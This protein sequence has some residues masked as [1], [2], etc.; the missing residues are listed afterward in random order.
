M[1]SPAVILLTQNASG[2][3]LAVFAFRARLYGQHLK[4]KHRSGLRLPTQAKQFACFSG[5]IGKKAK[6]K[7]RMGVEPTTYGLQNRCSAS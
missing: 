2:P 3:A 4:Q 1:G 5:L 7:P 6:K